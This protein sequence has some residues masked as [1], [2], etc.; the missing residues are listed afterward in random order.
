MILSIPPYYPSKN[1]KLR[2]I[3]IHKNDLWCNM[4]I[5]DLKI[6]R[7]ELIAMIIRGEQTIIPDG[8]TEIFENDVVV[9]YQST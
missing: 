6:P 9:V 4:K 1:E 2:E 5:K 7:N 3:E 8:N